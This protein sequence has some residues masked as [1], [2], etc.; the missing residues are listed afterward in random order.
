MFF[1]NYINLVLLLCLGQYATAQKIVL[2][3]DFD[4][5][6][7]KG[8]I[9][10]LIQKIQTGHSVRVGWQLDFDEDKK[11]DLEH[12]VDAEFISILEGHV[13]TQIETIYAQVPNADIPQIEILESTKRW[14]GVLGTNGKLVSRYLINDIYKVEDPNLEKYLRD[15]AGIKERMVATTWTVN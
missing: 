2:Q 1:K 12:W 5:Q 15:V 4:G 3:T 13:F 6:L 8:S 14:T 9:E 10:E 7:I 11:S